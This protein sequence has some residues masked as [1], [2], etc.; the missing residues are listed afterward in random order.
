MTQIELM[1]RWIVE[2]S[3]SPTDEVIWLLKQMNDSQLAEVENTLADELEN[4]ETNWG[5]K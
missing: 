5:E 1:A 4:V 2:H 3:E